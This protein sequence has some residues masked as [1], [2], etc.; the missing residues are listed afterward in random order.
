MPA[1]YLTAAELARRL[2]LS[3]ETVRQ[4]A[5]DGRIP[6]IRLSAKVIRFDAGQVAQ[7]LTSPRLPESGAADD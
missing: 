5:R 1:E 6:V 2:K 3:T 4:M 7:C